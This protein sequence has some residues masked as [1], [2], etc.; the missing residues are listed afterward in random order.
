MVRGQGMWES[1]D[2]PRLSEA[3]PSHSEENVEDQKIL[4]EI[5]A[6]EAQLMS[7]L[8][9]QGLTGSY[10]RGFSVTFWQETGFILEK[11]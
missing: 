6:T 11:F 7:F 10:V 9:E 1:S 8:I 5:Q 2:S 3:D 4:R